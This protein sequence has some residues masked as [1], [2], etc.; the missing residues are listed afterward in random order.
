M[1]AP[2]PPFVAHCLELLEA[3]GPMRSRRMFG[4]WGLYQGD[5]FIAIIAFERLFLKTD[6]ATRPLFEAAGC[7]PFVFETRTGSVSL[8]YWSAPAEA[9]DSPALMLPWARLALQA[10]VAARAAPKARS[11]VK[12]RAPAR[13]P[14]AATPRARRAAKPASRGG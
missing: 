13:A 8:G 1:P 6:A 10:A 11:A 14:R 9:L 5:V 2:T 7:E 4:G 12:P 3:L